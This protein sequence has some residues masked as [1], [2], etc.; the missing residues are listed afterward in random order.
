[1]RSHMSRRIGRPRAD[2]PK[3]CLD[4][5]SGRAFVTLAGKR[6]YLGRHGTP[7]SRDLYDRLIGEWIAQGRPRTVIQPADNGPT[8]TQI[9]MAFWAAA[10][11]LYPNSVCRDG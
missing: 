8:V 7:A 11:T 5:P 4:K 1:W 3:Y 2:K 10:Q 9:I 6:R